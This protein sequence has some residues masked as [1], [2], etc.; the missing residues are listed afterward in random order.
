MPNRKEEQAGFLL[1]AFNVS[2]VRNAVSDAPGPPT[3]TLR[4]AVLYGTAPRY[5][6]AN[7]RQPK[8]PLRATDRQGLQNS[9]CDIAAQA[10]K[11]VLLKHFL[12]FSH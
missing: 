5:G 3:V 12:S 9:A 1:P 4:R 2:V 8:F 11:S 6:W 7:V 10:G